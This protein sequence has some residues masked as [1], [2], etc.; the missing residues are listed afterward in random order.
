MHPLRG[1]R[2][3]ALAIAC[4]PEALAGALS[5]LRSATHAKNSRGPE[6]ARLTLWD[7]LSAATGHPSGGPLTTRV[8]ETVMAI[9]IEAGY[10]SSPGLLSSAKLRH[11]RAGHPWTDALQVGARDCVRAALR[12]LGA[13]QGAAASPL[14]RVRELLANLNPWSPGG[15][16]GQWKPSWW[17]VTGSSGRSS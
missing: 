8:I 12:G 2:A 6:R 7:E 15:Q 5:R 11:I 4:D 3:A 1:C 14:D 13:A 10:R 9:L 17:A 16:W